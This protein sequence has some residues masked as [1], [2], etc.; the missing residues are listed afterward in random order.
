VGKSLTDLDEDV[1]L[2]E[3]DDS[4]LVEGNVDDLE[5]EEDME[6][7]E[8]DSIGSYQSGE[9]VEGNSTNGEGDTINDD[10]D[11]SLSKIFF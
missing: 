5:S 3:E 11:I 2:G 1:P 8:D 4:F 6:D 7:S 9:E 10:S